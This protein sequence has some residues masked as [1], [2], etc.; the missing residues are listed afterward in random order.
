MTDTPTLEHLIGAY[1]NQD[2][3]DDYAGVMDGVD[4]FV[5]HE[6]DLALTLAEEIRALLAEGLPESRL[7]QLMTQWG[8]GFVAGADGYRGWL[9]QIAD[10]VRRATA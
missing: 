3:W 1:L 9:S 10:R 8:V 2:L 6:P 7:S 5:H 4:D